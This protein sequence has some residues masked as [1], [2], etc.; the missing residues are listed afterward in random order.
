MLNSQNNLKEAPLGDLMAA[1][2]VVDTLR[3][4][5]GIAERELDGEGRK[6]RLLARLRDLYD[7]QGIDVSDQVLQEGIEALEQERFQYKP[8]SPSWQTK[9]AHIWVSRSRWGKPIGFLS[10][11]AII[12]LAYYIFAE[13]LPEHRLQANLPKQLDSVLDD[14]KGSSKKPELIEQA[15]QSA[16]IAKRAITQEDYTSAKTA[17]ADMS[18]VAKLLNTAYTIRVWVRPCIGRAERM[19]PARQHLRGIVLAGEWIEGAGLIGIYFIWWKWRLRWKPLT[20]SHP[21]RVQGGRS[22]SNGSSTNIFE[23]HRLLCEDGCRSVFC[24]T[25]CF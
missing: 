25:T 24:C 20:P 22:S 23:H 19:P 5:Q 21:S 14:I 4:Q 16:I 3:H 1:M 6:Q 10:I 13:V 9:L 2:D 15:E 7:A 17:L 11:V 8:V 18:S 12:F